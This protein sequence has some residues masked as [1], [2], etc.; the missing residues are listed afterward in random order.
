LSTF[1][2]LAV[3]ISIILGL[4]ITHLLGGLG[5]LLQDRVRVRTY[6]PAV[7]WVCVLLL[8]HVQTW[9]A[10]F[11]L[12]SLDS[13]TFFVFLLVLMQPVVL[14]MLAALVLPDARADGE[15]DLR[16]NYYAQ[17][18]W[19]FALAVLLLVVSLARDLT[20]AG[21]LP[22]AF[23]TSVHVLLLVLWGVAAITQRELYHRC[24]AVGTALVLA[25]YVAVLF[26]DLP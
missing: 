15:R 8:L 25:A 21:R 23:N 5:R 1:D 14:F 20:L 4:G 10:M 7:V 3:L 12:R 2:Y 22:G 11:G 9:W 17:S 19:F 18:R 6:W 16:A 13:W 26:R 24:V